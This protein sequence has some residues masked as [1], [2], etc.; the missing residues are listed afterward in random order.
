ME[1]DIVINDMLLLRLRY[2]I[3]IFLLPGLGKFNVEGINLYF[4]LFL[5]QNSAR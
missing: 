1:I 4:I 3:Y 5:L 2:L